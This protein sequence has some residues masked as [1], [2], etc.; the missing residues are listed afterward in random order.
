MLPGPWRFMSDVAERRDEAR[1][2]IENHIADVAHAILDV[3]A[4]NPQEPHVAQQVGDAA[5][6]EHRR[7]QRQI[8][9]PGRRLKA[10]GR[11]LLSAPP[12]DDGLV[13]ADD[14]F[15][16]PDFRGHCR[17]GIGELIVRAGPLKENVHQDVQRNE[18]VVDDR[19]RPD[20]GVVVAE[21]KHD[22]VVS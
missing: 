12:V 7:Q 18:H 17:P 9:R 11:E 8:D 4:E 19:H 1:H 6:H 21:G 2:E 3:V 20:V 22:W 10:G 13:F 5:V 14:V 15:A 16:G